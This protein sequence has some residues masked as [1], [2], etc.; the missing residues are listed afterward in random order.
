[1]ALEIR[2][3]SYFNCTIR[4]QPG[5]AY[6]LLSRLAAGEVNLL[7]FSAVPIGPDRAM[8]TMF[9]DRVDRLCVLGPRPDYRSGASG[10]VGH[11]RFAAH[12][13]RP[14][15]GAGAFDPRR[16][17]PRWSPSRDRVSGRP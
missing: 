13:L 12:A 10:A 3:V 11:A 14:V 5:S 4:D 1:M 8:L 15:T 6:S 16:S 7:A 17:H 2:R 9:P